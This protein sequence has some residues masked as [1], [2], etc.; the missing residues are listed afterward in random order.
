[1][2]RKSSSGIKRGSAGGGLKEN[3]NRVLSKLSELENNSSMNPF[4]PIHKLRDEMTSQGMSN[5]DFTN[6]LKALKNKG[7]VSMFIEDRTVYSE[8]EHRKN[9]YDGE[10]YWGLITSN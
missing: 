4:I 10:Y 5:N 3:S 6:A 9:Y 1:M 2:S 7:R 8:A